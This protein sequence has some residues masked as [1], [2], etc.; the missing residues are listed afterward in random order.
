MK[1]LIIMV[2]EGVCKVNASDETG[3]AGSGTKDG[4]SFRK[5]KN[6]IFL[7]AYDSRT[8]AEY[9]CGVK[10]GTL[11]DAILSHR[12]LPG[13]TTAPVKSATE[14]T[15]EQMAAFIEQAADNNELIIGPSI[16]P[17]IV[18]NFY[19]DDFTGKSDEL[20]GSCQISIS[21]LLS[22][23]C[24][25]REITSRL[26][27]TGTNPVI[28]ANSNEG[29]DN[30][31]KETQVKAGEVTVELGFQNV[32]SILSEAQATMD[33]LARTGSAKVRSRLGS[34]AGS[35]RA[36]KS[37]E[38]GK[39]SRGAALSRSC[40]GAVVKSGAIAN[41]TPA[42]AT[43]V[44]KVEEEAARVK[45]ENE[46][47]L[48]EL[49]QLKEAAKVA[50]STPTATASSR[51]DSTSGFATDP[52]LK[53]KLST[54]ESELQAVKAEKD[55]L[56]STLTTL[57]EQTAKADSN[58]SD[59]SA[60]TLKIA[61]LQ[62]QVE[63]QKVQSELTRKQIAQ[64]EAEKKE[65]LAKLE[66]QHKVSDNVQTN[67]SST[68]PSGNGVS[69]AATASELWKELF[70]LLV[71]RYQSSALCK[72]H[73]A[74]NGGVVESNKVLVTFVSM[75]QTCSGSAEVDEECLHT[76]SVNL[77]WGLSTEQCGLLIKDMCV[78][79]SEKDHIAFMKC[80]EVTVDKFK[81]F[82]VENSQL[83]IKLNPWEELVDRHQSANSGPILDSMSAGNSVV[84][85][86]S[87]HHPRGQPKQS[88]TAPVTPNTPMATTAAGYSTSASTPSHS[89]PT[90]PAHA[91]VVNWDV[92]PLPLDKIPGT[93]TPVWSRR[94]DTKTGKTYYANNQL[95]TTQW[96]HPLDVGKAKS[97]G[98][99][100]GKNSQSS[101]SGATDGTNGHTKGISRTQGHVQTGEGN[102]Q[103]QDQGQQ[104][105]SDAA[106][107]PDPPK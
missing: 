64:A 58:G 82:A 19:N 93:N 30:L 8:A 40:S 38:V 55:N 16:T 77:N 34:K 81:S 63:Q 69:S 9:Q 104:S 13:T 85:S 47:L 78:H 107:L 28:A 22:S 29:K 5:N 87:L 57:K 96:K 10:S 27:Y 92:V 80:I 26:T 72:R 21:S 61:E 39:G 101:A 90:P 94:K 15:T 49:Q 73:L 68:N 52:A 42:T 51:L 74:A 43:D 41:T 84:T 88:A 105:A 6:F 36:S 89:V 71:H 12:P 60:A 33:Y 70:T 103:Q 48:K 76:V 45:L 66:A 4:K 95:Q 98:R 56:R 97:R 59:S 31:A 32:Q 3:G 91:P 17:R 79:E 1:Y 86:E 83:G 23:G 102:N 37:I 25:V 44:A 53:L 50:S 46:K 65:L 100:M 54:L 11:L 106:K 18:I 24:S 20:L 75:L 99:R 62:N 7:T 14:Y 67:G 2:R 35:R